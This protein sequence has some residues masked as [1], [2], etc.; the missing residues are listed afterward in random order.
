MVY[1]FRVMTCDTYYETHSSDPH[2]VDRCAKR[3]SEAGAARAF[4]IL[5]ASTTIFVLINLLVTGWTIK[6]LGVKRALIIQVF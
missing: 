4:A 1:V 3:E 6:R 2:D 5:S